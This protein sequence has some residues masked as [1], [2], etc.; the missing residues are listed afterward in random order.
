MFKTVLTGKESIRNQL[1][2]PINP[3]YNSGNDSFIIH[4]FRV[5]NMASP[6]LSQGRGFLVGQ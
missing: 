1:Y 5:K 4:L 3:S 6:T 2:T